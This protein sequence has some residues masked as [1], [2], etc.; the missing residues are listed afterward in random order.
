MQ[1]YQF[2]VQDSLQ[3]VIAMPVMALQSQCP[4]TWDLVNEKKSAVLVKEHTATGHAS[5]ASRPALE[6]GT[7]KEHVHDIRHI[8]IAIFALSSRR[9]CCVNMR[10]SPTGSF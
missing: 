10:P 9:L 4:S 2:E 3:D 5:L 6:V 7:T 1:A 8:L